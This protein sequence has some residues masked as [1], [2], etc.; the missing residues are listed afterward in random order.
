MRKTWGKKRTDG[1][2]SGFEARVAEDLKKRGIPFEYE[3]TTFVLHVVDVGRLCNSCGSNDVARVSRY[4]PDFRLGN[5]RYVETKGRLTS[6]E[7]RIILA[8]WEQVAKPNDLG[9]YVLL[10]RDNWMTKAKKQ[11]YSDWLKRMGIPYAVG[12][13][14]PDEWTR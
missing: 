8:F 14:I 7:R 6:K 1:Y 2:R 12:E 4:T 10:Q 9:Y 13:K 11:R 3:P 5:N